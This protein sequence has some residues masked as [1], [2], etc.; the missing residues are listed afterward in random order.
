MTKTYQ[1]GSPEGE[2]VLAAIDLATA[3]LV[4]PGLL[5]NAWNGNAVLAFREEVARKIVD[6]FALDPG[7]GD[8]RLIWRA[9]G[10]VVDACEDGTVTLY[11]PDA[12]GRYQIGAFQWAWQTAG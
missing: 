9:D 5:V 4:A 11:A 8:A 7:D 1:V 6:A 2:E 3:T 12:D 10:V